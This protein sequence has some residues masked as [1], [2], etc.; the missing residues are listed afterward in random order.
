[1]IRKYKKE[2]RILS[3]VVTLFWYAQYVYIPCQTPYLTAQ[4]VSTTFVG[5]IVGAY[6]VSQMLAR[7]PVGVMA[8]T[9]NKHKYFIICGVIASGAGSLWRIVFPGRTGFL[10][11]N[12]FSGFA[13]AMWISFM[14][15][16]CSYF[17]S[18]HQQ[19][20]TSRMVMYNNVGM[21]IAFLVST[22][23]YD[24]FGM[25]FLCGTSCVAGGIGALLAAMLEKTAAAAENRKETGSEHRPS[26]GQLLSVCKGKRL[27]AFACLMLLQQGIQMSTVMSFTTQLMKDSGAAA[28][29]IGFAS[30]VYM[31]SSVIMSMA[32]SSKIC[33]G[34]GG[35]FWIPAVF[36]VVA[37][38]CL[39]APLTS[40]LWAFLILQILPGISS[41]IL[42]SFL[43]SEA[44]AGVP[45]EKK[46][47]AMGFFQAVYAVGMTGIPI[48]M[49]RIADCFSMFAGFA[50]LAGLA[51]AGAAAA[52][53]LY[54]SVL[55]RDR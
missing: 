53:L 46:S 54:R 30:V 2:S 24:S 25:K 18:G 36:L 1:M 20:G 35:R 38:Y 6:G 43:I 49:G 3:A 39:L 52:T 37:L 10:I 16:Y 23:F 8:D 17:D 27:I 13:S 9:V 44:M 50:V 11:A 48:V 28:A 40:A 4:S 47:T 55:P 51:V 32:A 41:G 29:F 42:V 26:V 12:L 19:V 31:L 34:P 45:L 21:L 5:I 7:L 15:L 22:L 14:V 33:T